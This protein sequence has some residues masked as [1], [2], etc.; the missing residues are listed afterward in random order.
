MSPK[1]ICDGDS[2]E[3]AKSVDRPHKP[4]RDMSTQTLRDVRDESSQSSPEVATTS[5]IT[6]QTDPWE[7]Q[8]DVVGEASLFISLVADTGSVHYLKV[9]WCIASLCGRRPHKPAVCLCATA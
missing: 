8:C 4:M 7:E 2:D 9:L 6:T 3:W 5:E 1:I